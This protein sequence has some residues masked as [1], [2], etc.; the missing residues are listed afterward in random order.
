[1]MEKN[2]SSDCLVGEWC[3]GREVPQGGGMRELA[4]TVKFSLDRSL[5]YADAHIS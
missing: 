3:G 4:G 2:Q 1:M 5:S